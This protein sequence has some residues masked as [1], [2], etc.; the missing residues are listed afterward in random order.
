MTSKDSDYSEWKNVPFRCEQS[1]ECFTDV[2]KTDEDCPQLLSL[3][4]LPEQPS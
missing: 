2:S 1:R 3:T 4:T